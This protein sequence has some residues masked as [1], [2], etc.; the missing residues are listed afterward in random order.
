MRMV[1]EEC[2][3]EGFVCEGVVGKVSRGRVLRRGCG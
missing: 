3:W 1:W 2:G